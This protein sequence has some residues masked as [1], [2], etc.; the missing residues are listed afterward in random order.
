[1]KKYNQ[2]EIFRFLGAFTVLIFHT[3]KN[4]TFYPKLPL[5][6]QNGTIWVYF[7]FLLSGFMLCNSYFNKNEI[8]L[9]NFYL[10]RFFKFY[11]LYFFSLLLLFV[12]SLKYKEKLIFSILM[13]QS[14]ILGRA[15]DQHYNYSAWYLSVLMFLLVLFP[16]LLKFL[17]NSPKYFKYFVI[18][19]TVYTYYFF[20]V[21]N[22]YSSNNDYIQHLINYFPLVHISTFT[23]GMLVFYKIQNIEK[24]SKY[25]YFIIFYLIFLIFFVQF[26]KIIPYVSTLI[27]LSFVPLILFLFLDNGIVSKFLSNNFFKYL[28]SLSFSIYILH[29]PLHHIYVTYINDINTNLH[30]FIFFIIVIL[31]S[32]VSKIFIE[33]KITKFLLSKYLKDF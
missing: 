12:Y 15:T 13:I 21:F 25:S 17:K 24:K 2:F 27:S 18:I 16:F 4:T 31:F 9:K 23:L 22:K 19:I 20:I 5:L 11:P 10:S 8:S 6:F 29:V 30:F 14:F 1:M 26:N 3:A 7:F 32:I 33:T 28:G